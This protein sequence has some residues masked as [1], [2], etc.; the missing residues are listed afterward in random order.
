MLWV[1]VALL[2]VISALIGWLTNVLAVRLLFRPY[3]P[4]RLPLPGY[5]LQGMLPKYRR[6]LAANVGR[7]MENE[8]LP[9]DHLLVY[10]RSEE[11]KK[12]L[13]HLTELAVRARVMDRL[14]AFLPPSLKRSVGD[15]LSEQVHKELPALLDEL[16]KRFGQKLK[17]EFQLGRLVEERLN[18]FELQKLEEIVL[19]AAGRELRHIEILGGVIGFLIGLLQA[20]L[21]LFLNFHH[22]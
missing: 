8:L 19:Q 12:E 20:G 15:L 9:V 18:E 14:P 17:E 16:L 7:L 10:L 5:R 6:E 13:I 1:W 22:F 3:Q 11:M 4:V 2:P 21:L